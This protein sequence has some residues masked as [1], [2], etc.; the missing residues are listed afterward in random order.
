MDC[1]S[2]GFS[3]HGIFQ[4]GILEWIAISSSRGSFQPRDW[5]R[6]SCS[7]C[8]GRWI[9]YHRVTW[10][11]L[12]IW[13]VGKINRSTI[14][15]ILWSRWVLQLPHFSVKLLETEAVCSTA[16]PTVW[17]DVSVDYSLVGFIVFLLLLSYCPDHLN[18]KKNLSMSFIFISHIK[19]F[20]VWAEYFFKC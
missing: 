15:F 3:V 8:T 20:M 14:V 11:A 4:A 6:G 13:P 5:T 1:S 10:E 7:S 16:L 12:S 9:L 17:C 2:P 19:S 18:L